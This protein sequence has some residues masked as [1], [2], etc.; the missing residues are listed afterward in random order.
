LE[1]VGVTAT[2]CEVL[3]S[4]PQCFKGTPLE[5]GSLDYSKNMDMEITFEDSL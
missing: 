3:S 4:Q 1:N 2:G 5:E